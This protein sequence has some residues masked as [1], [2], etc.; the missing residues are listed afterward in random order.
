MNRKL[1]NHKIMIQQLEEFS[2]AKAQCAFESDR[3]W[4]EEH[5]RKLFRHIDAQDPIYAF[6]SYMRNEVKSSLINRLGAAT[7]MKIGQCWLAM[8]P[9]F[10]GAIQNT[11]SC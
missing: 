3:E 5:V 7:D 9:T 2:L 8:I 11:L 10:F 1:L 4:V 6:D